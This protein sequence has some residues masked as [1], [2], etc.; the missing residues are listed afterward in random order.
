M[1]QYAKRRHQLGYFGPEDE[2]LEEA[3]IQA[4]PRVGRDCRRDSMRLR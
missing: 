2:E 1:N 4:L 3:P